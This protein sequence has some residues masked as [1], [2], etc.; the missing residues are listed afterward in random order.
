MF[1]DSDVQVN[2]GDVRGKK[3]HMKW[4]LLNVKMSTSEGQ[5]AQAVF[6]RTAE[7]DYKRG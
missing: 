4:P 3:E 7:H 5:A 6:I 2:M 1:H